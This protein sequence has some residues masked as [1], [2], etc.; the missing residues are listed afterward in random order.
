M[1]CWKQVTVASWTN[2]LRNR[3]RWFIG[4]QMTIASWVNKLPNSR[5]SSQLNNWSQ[6]MTLWEQVTIA[7]WTNKQKKKKNG[8]RWFIGQQMTIA[9]WV[10]KLNNSRISSQLDNWSQ[11]M[12]LWEQITVASWTN[13]LRKGERLFIRQQMTI[14]SWVNKLPN[15]R[16]SSQLDNW[17]QAMTLWNR[18]Q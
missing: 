10:K 7:S 12:T 2:N 13:K 5:S 17:S 11:A 1:T 15:S 9:S 16:I 6:A 14:V 3:E 8:E 18:S 4:Q